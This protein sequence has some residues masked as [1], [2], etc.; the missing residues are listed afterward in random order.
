MNNLKDQAEPPG[1]SGAG[2]EAQKSSHVGRKI[3]DHSTSHPSHLQEETAQNLMTQSELF[4]QYSEQNNL[5]LNLTNNMFWFEFGGN[6][7]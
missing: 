1:E 7:I 2:S 4:K 5:Y 3:I 6:K